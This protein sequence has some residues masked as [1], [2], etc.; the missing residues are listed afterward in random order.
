MGARVRRAAA[1]QWYA[2][3]RDSLCNIARQL[4]SRRREAAILSYQGGSSWD[5]KLR[6]TACADPGRMV[7]TPL[8]RPA[9]QRGP[10]PAAPTCTARSSGAD[11]ICIA[12]SGGGEPAESELQKRMKGIKHKVLVLSGHQNTHNTVHATPP[13]RQLSRQDVLRTS[14]LTSCGRQEKVVSGRAHLPHRLHS[15]LLRM[16][17]R[18]VCWTSTSVGRPSRTLSGFVASGCSKETA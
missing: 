13:Q 4:P 2:L 17:A 15:I 10:R 11:V 5:V 3:P 6:R 8:A 16:G 9:A 1:R 14:S 12:G 7:R 18:W